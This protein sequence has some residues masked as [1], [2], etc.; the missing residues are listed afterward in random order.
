LEP[1]APVRQALVYR[2]FLDQIEPS[3]RVYHASDPAE[4]LRRAAAVYQERG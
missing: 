4:R 1:V 2:S 3:E